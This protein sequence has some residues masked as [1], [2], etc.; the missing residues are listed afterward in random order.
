MARV[1]FIKIFFVF[2]V[3]TICSI[4]AVDDRSEGRPPADAEEKANV[5]ES[6]E[7]I[8]VPDSGK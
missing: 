4:Y 5:G 2:C 8:G 1:N 6:P 3:M 7:K